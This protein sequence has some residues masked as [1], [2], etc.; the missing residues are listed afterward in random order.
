MKRTWIPVA[1]LSALALVFAV[2]LACTGGSGGGG[3]SKDEGAP[4]VDTEIMAYL[5]EARALHH[6]A[7]LKEDANDLDGAIAAMD[8]LA[9]AKRPHPERTVPEIDEVLADTYARLAELE[10]KKGDLDEAAR[11]VDKGLERAP[12]PTYFRGHLVEVQGLVEEARAARLADAGKAA[13]AAKARERAIALL[14]EVVKIQDQVIQRSLAS[15]DAGA[16]G[17][18]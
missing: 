7:N 13:E 15:K 2:V 10:L 12:E 3:S 4:V 16:E 18:R 14:E 9:A 5:S 11:A 6:Q 1:L 17:G 8:R